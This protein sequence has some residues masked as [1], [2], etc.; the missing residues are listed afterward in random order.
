LIRGGGHRRN[1]RPPRELESYAP[2]QDAGTV[3]GS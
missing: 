1:R 3:F 2:L